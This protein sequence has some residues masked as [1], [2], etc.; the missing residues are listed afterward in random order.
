M[1]LLFKQIMWGISKLN[2]TLSSVISLSYKN[3]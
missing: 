1:V 2:I 3:K